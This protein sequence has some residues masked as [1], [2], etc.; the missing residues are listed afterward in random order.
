MQLRTELWFVGEGVYCIQLSR[1]EY[2]ETL[3]DCLKSVSSYVVLTCI[4]YTQDVGKE[5]HEPSFV[6]M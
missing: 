5:F 1:V 6:M 4:F 2:S 3:S